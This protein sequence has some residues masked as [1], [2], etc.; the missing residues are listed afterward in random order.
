MKIQVEQE[1]TSVERK[2]KKQEREPNEESSAR[3]KPATGGYN[4]RD[5]CTQVRHRHV[6]NRVPGQSSRCHC[7]LGNLSMAPL[8]AAYLAACLARA[9]GHSCCLSCIVPDASGQSGP[10]CDIMAAKLGLV[11]ARFLSWSPK[12][13]GTH[14]RIL[15]ASC[16]K[17]LYGVLGGNVKRQSAGM[18]G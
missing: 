4:K 12:A 7:P 1:R 11:N 17:L 18:A 2:K 16:P 3:R 8:R 5:V 6:R 10:V 13:Q 9:S 14:P 15:N